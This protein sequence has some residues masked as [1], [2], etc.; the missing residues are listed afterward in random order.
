MQVKCKYASH[1]DMLGYI[2]VNGDSE[3]CTEAI[4]DQ[5]MECKH[6]E[7]DYS[8]MS[9]EDINR[10]KDDAYVALREFKTPKIK[11]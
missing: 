5:C 1:D 7:I 2:C 10:V 11:S 9:K 3:N 6:F 4:L 8:V